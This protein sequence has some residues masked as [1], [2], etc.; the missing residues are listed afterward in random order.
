MLLYWIGVIVGFVIIYCTINL[1]FTSFY[2]ID[3]NN[4][5]YF[6]LFGCFLSWLVPIIEIILL[7]G[8]FIYHIIGFI[9]SF[10]HDLTTK[11]NTKYK[12]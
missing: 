12:K 2:S 4:K 8:Y 6:L 1:F 3:M 10:P 5:W 7:I 11:T 9:L